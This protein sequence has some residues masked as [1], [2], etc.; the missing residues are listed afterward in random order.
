MESENYSREIAGPADTMNEC[1]GGPAEDC[2]AVRH[3]RAGFFLRAGD[4]FRL[5]DR[6]ANKIDR[7]ARHLFRAEERRWT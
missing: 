6:L 5:P 3:S 2:A 1:D 7:L 4:R